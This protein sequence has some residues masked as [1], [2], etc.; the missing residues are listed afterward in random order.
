MQGTPA[1]AWGRLGR[2]ALSYVLSSSLI[3]GPTLAQ[4][5][6]PTQG[7]APGVNVITPDG[8]T[9]TKQTITGG[10][11]GSVTGI[12][13][14]TISGGNA[15]NSFSVFQE[16]AGNTVNLYVP[17]GAGNLVNIVRDAP[18]VVNGILNAYKS[19]QLGGNVF[20]AD[21]QGFI[22]GA[23]GVLNVGSL[24][25]TTP[26]RQSLEGVIRP[27]GTVDNAAAQSLLRGDLPLSP[28]GIISIHGRINAETGVR[29]SGQE[30]HFGAGAFPPGAKPGHQQKFDATVNTQGRVE[31]AAISVA[32]GAIEIVAAGDAS[33]AGRLSADGASGNAGRIAVTAGRDVTIAKSA[34]LSASAKGA[35]GDAGTVVVKAGRNLVARDGAQ[36]AASA[37]GTGNAGSIELSAAG[38]ETIGLIIT[39]LSSK[40]GH[41]GS[42]LYDPTDLII[43]STSSP[44]AGTSVLPNIFNPGGNVTLL[45]S[46]SITVE[47]NGIIDTRNLSGGFSAGDSGTISITAPTISL[48]SGAQLR[49]GVLN[50]G[51]S[52]WKAG[53][54]SLIATQTSGGTASIAAAGSLISG[55][56]LTLT[57]TASLTQTG[58]LIA[59][60]Q[61]HATIELQSATLNATGDVALTATATAN[62]TAA[63]LTPVATLTSD[64]FAAVD[65]LGSSKV[66]TTHGG[67]TLAATATTDMEAPLATPD[68]TAL[69]SGTALAAVVKATNTARAQLGDTGALSA[70]GAIGIT[71]TGNTTVKAIA[72]GSAVSGVVGATVAVG[73]IDATT[74]AVIGGQA[75]VAG[76]ALTVAA[77]STDLLVATA[78]ATAGG[79]TTPDAG[80]QSANTLS[81]PK[82]GQ[83]ETAGGQQIGVAA[84]I[85]VADLTN[86]SS[87]TMGSSVGSIIRGSANI[88]TDT[89]NTSTAT[90]DGEGVA[91]GSTGVGAAVALGLSHVANDA[92]LAQQLTATGVDVTAVM[93]PGG[94]NVFTASATSGGGGSN[95]GVAGSVALSLADTESMS[96]RSFRAGFRSKTPMFS[97]S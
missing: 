29:L 74:T 16:G 41:A 42:L 66:T 22:V 54:V 48:L 45:A 57:A 49:A 94:K 9:A 17:K 59:Q 86:N 40:G 14:G 63:A 1:N 80:S 65:V 24:T 62:G 21:P 61:A 2:E 72:D 44:P 85:A 70:T 84:A 95:V 37:A 79:A 83:Y 92:T 27:N 68:I 18:V 20:F 15:F 19:G 93:A 55:G 6:G 7:P 46:N 96:S 35:A 56:N 52:V 50:Q 78:K 31:A 64:V 97:L 58:L 13:T 77:H 39:D 23:S 91:T 12:R 4:A 28:D 69:L 8:R 90:A 33:V 89:A 82:Y 47:G 87:A 67:I 26:T 75:T 81:D 25:V 30:V 34:R 5:Q 73:L 88:T 3:F 32:N 38:T 36:I 10:V 11:T 43:G 76:N 51:G 71:A 60:P 53:D